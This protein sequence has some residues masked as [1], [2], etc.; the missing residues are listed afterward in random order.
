MCV[1]NSRGRSSGKG[2]PQPTVSLWFLL[3]VPVQGRRKQLIRMAD[4]GIFSP[5]FPRD[6]VVGG[7][8]RA[9]YNFL[10]SSISHSFKSPGR[11]KGGAEGSLKLMT[12]LI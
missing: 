1:F 9:R 12:T 5:F 6:T 2:P 4:T 10:K 3:F 8:F 7:Y 11:A